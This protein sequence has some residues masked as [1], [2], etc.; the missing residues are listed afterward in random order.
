M[1]EQL[2][3]DKLNIARNKNPGL[4]CRTFV[5]LCR[6]AGHPHVSIRAFVRIDIT[7]WTGPDLEDV[8][9]AFWDAMI[10]E[11]RLLW[12]YPRKRSRYRWRIWVVL[13]RIAGRDRQHKE[14]KSETSP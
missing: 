5:L 8:A 6:G 12:T 13:A 9:R 3:R 4:I 10:K 7:Y 14:I 2:R 1:S 11:D